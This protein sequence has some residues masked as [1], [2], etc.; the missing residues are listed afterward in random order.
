M[1]AKMLGVAGGFGPLAA[2]DFFCKLLRSRALVAGRE[3]YH[4]LFE[5][6]PL[7][8][9]AVPLQRDAGM[10]ARKLHVFR[11]CQSLARRGADAILLPC[12]AS[13]VFRDEIQAELEV[14]VVDLMEAVARHLDAVLPDGGKVGLLASDYVRHANLFESRL[15]HRYRFVY[16]SQAGQAGVMRAV[17]G[18][19]GIK[20]GATD[21][22]CL[23]SICRACA[24]LAEGGAEVILP[25]IT[26]LAIVAG[27]LRSRGIEAVDVNQVYADF[28]ISARGAASACSAP[29]RLGVLGGVGP[30]ATVDFMGKVVRNTK[31]ERDQDHIKMIVEHNPQIPDRT[32]NLVGGGE[33]PTVALY[34]ACRR[35]ESEGASAIAIPC[36]TA[37]AFVEHIQPHL[38]VP[39]VNMLTEVV[40]HIVA[41]YGQGAR[42]GLLA[43]SGTIASGVYHD[44][45]QELVDIVV[46]DP[47]HQDMVMRAIYG[48]RG[49]KAGFT[50]GECEILV[51]AAID[52]LAESGAYVQILGCTELPL[53]FPQ[54]D[55][56]P[57]K[58]GATVALIDPTDVLAKRCVALAT[59]SGA[60]PEGYRG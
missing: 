12:F 43:T 24:E 9:A 15:A 19:D 18:E 4:L 34:A 14:P 33:D 13:Q 40:R 11:V 45:A 20:A 5:Q 36:N 8:D 53:I 60:R 17:Y 21:G 54:V 6:F 31:A 56:L 52:H 59:R 22:P 25:G 23:E 42:V 35:L 58:S 3:K 32:A 46:P 10:G 29:F 55:A 51:E 27:Q 37:H 1:T 26:E 47:Q 28:A 48:P 16:P 38:G 7:P 39:I 44:A 50:Q 57:L 49:V 41:A 2:A 30:A